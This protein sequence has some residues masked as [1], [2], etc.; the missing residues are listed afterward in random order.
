MF[1][2]RNKCK[3]L[4]VKTSLLFVQL[5][6]INDA[7]E[8]K[9]ATVSLGESSLLYGMD[10]QSRLHVYF[11]SLPLI[12]EHGWRVD[13]WEER[14]NSRTLFLF[15]LF[16]CNIVDIICFL[17]SLIGT[18]C[19]GLWGGVCMSVCVCKCARARV[20]L[21]LIHSCSSCLSCH[22]LLDCLK[23]VPMFE[24]RKKKVFFF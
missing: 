4:F 5:H 16:N 6:F 12:C 15:L 8:K 24:K 23:Q 10:L 9:T 7:L 20:K 11:P 14:R 21:F 3:H 19:T 2:K 17:F 13:M 22:C 18:F 1:L